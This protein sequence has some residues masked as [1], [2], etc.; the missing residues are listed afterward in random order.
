MMRDRTKIVDDKG[1]PFTRFLDLLG[2][3]PVI[4]FAVVLS[5]FI[6]VPGAMKAALGVLTWIMYLI[7]YMFAEA[8][9]G[10]F[11]R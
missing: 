3:N 6:I 8:L 1:G 10:G 11:G 9:F 2:R 5:F 4:T 7:L